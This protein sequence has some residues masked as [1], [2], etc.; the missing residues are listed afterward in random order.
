MGPAPLAS[1]CLEC[2]HGLA[3]PS[4]VWALSCLPQRAWPAP[5]GCAFPCLNPPLPPPCATPAAQ[6]L[7]G[8]AE[9]V[10]RG[11][12]PGL[13]HLRLARQYSPDPPQL[14][15]DS[16]E[17]SRR[18]AVLAGNA[19]AQQAVL[20][21]GLPGHGGNDSELQPG[22][23]GMPPVPLPQEMQRL[24]LLCQGGL[25]SYCR[26]CGSSG[27]GCP[28]EAVYAQL[29][30]ESGPCHNAADLSFLGCLARLTSLVRA[31]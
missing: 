13:R 1:H 2:G 29:L 28:C 6:A 15:W 18:E 9:L 10:W 25:G 23:A 4:C 31:L 16:L 12:F 20:E 17:M 27:P 5:D 22:S 7:E 24:G 26:L 19:R 30:R 14:P 3:C 8:F 11:Q 21:A